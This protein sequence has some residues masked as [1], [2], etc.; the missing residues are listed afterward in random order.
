MPSNAIVTGLSSQ[1]NGV[2]EYNENDGSYHYS[3]NTLFFFQFMETKKW[4]LMQGQGGPYCESHSDVPYPWLC[5]EP[6]IDY[7]IDASG[8]TILEATPI[9][10]RNFNYTTAS[11]DGAHRFRR[12][13]SLG[14]V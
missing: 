7:G 10:L 13:Y 4:I 11:E 3:D 9:N 8:I 14:Y 1:Y 12:L 6:W 5:N 2:Y